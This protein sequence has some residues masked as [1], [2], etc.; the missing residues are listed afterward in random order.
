V[1]ALTAD[2]EADVR[3]RCLAAGMDS[4]LTKPVRLAQLER[5]VAE[6]WGEQLKAV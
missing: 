6:T 1:I 3:E 5:V 4:C 2:S